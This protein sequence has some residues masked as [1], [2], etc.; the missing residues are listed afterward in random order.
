MDWSEFFSMGGRAL[1]VWGSYGITFAFIFME[2]ILLINRKK[3]IERQIRFQ[4]D[5]SET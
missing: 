2:L 3:K 4:H 1:Y 5:T